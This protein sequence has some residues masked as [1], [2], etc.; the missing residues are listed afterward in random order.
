MESQQYSLLE[1]TKNHWETVYTTKDSTQVSWFTEHLNL[2]LDFIHKTGVDRAGKIIDVGGGASTLVDDLLERGFQNITVLDV[3]QSAI[4]LAQ[5]RLGCQANSVNWLGADIRQVELPHHFYDV[6]H[7][8][9]VFHFLTDPE[10]R[11]TYLNTVKYAVKPG[12]HLIMATFAID[13]PQ[14]CSGLD[15]VRYNSTSIKDEFGDIFE[16]VD[17]TDEFHKTPFATEQK[18][19]YCYLKK[20]Q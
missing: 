5:K 16:L 13:G 3:S 1:P 9:A 14:R 11:Q 17:T 10:D 19:T 6:W 20:S 2:S 18:F 12:G 4:S 8:R 15:V 7:D